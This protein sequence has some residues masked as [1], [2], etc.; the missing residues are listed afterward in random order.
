MK[1]S[2]QCGH[3]K[4]QTADRADCADHADCADSFREEETG[5]KTRWNRFESTPKPL[6]TQVNTQRS[7]GEPVLFKYRS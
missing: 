5:T 7:S 6:K 4:T 3:V 1:C 2:V